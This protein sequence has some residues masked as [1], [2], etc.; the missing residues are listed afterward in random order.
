MAG[1][2]APVSGV[3]VNDHDR[4]FVTPGLGHDGVFSASPALIA[5]SCDGRV[6]AVKRPPGRD[7]RASICPWMESMGAG[8]EKV[9]KKEP[10]EV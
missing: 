3:M 8:E 10:L 6:D 7:E 2:R 9:F 5:R 1:S 4:W